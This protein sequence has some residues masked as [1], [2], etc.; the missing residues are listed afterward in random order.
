MN[1]EIIIDAI[2]VDFAKTNFKFFNAILNL[3]TKNNKITK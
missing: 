3:I 1:K 2:K